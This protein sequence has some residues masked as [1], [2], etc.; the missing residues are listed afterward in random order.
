MY[1]LGGQLEADPGD[2][3]AQIRVSTQVEGGRKDKGSSGEL[4]CSP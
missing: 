4:S 2:T 1:G 3:P